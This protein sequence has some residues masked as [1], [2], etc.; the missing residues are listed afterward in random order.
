MKGHG[1]DEAA[2]AVAVDLVK[3]L[4]HEAPEPGP[5]DFVKVLLDE[6]AETGAIDLVKVLLLHAERHSAE[7]EMEKGGIINSNLCQYV[8]FLQGKALNTHESSK[9]YVTGDKCM[10]LSECVVCSSS[11]L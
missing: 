4:L 7:T 5:V 11:V 2:E 10:F 3:V 8:T 1:L 9:A 6:T